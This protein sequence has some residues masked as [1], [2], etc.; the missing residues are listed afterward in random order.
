MQLEK[1][2]NNF[3]HNI[4]LTNKNTNKTNIFDIKVLPQFLSVIVG[5]RI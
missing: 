3:Y 4:F 1:G 5:E 2:K